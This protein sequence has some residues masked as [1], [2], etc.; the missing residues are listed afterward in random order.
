MFDFSVLLVNYN[1]TCPHCSHEL[2]L[3]D[4]MFKDDYRGE[5]ICGYC[6]EG[7]EELVISEEGEDGMLL[8]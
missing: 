6:R 2:S 4:V 3:G 1:T 8:K 5:I 7:Y